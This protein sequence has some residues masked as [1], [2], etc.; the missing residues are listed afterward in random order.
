MEGLSFSDAAFVK[1]TAGLS[2]R[3]GV[4][5][6]VGN[7]VPAQKQPQTAT[8]SDLKEML[9]PSTEEICLPQ[10]LRKWDYLT[11][12]PPPEISFLSGL[13]AS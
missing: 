10:G 12:P 8:L 1:G 6:T 7:F 2:S 3:S 5:R 13:C 11:K 9:G 4:G